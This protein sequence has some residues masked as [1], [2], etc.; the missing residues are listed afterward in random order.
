V[1]IPPEM[2][3]R[4]GDGRGEGRSGSGSGDV[5]GGMCIPPEMVRRSGDGAGE[6][7]RGNG[8]GNVGGG[9]GEGVCR[10]VRRWQRRQRR[11]W[12]R[13]RRRRGQNLATGGAVPAGSAML[14][15]FAFRL[16][17]LSFLS[18]PR[19]LPIFSDRGVAIMLDT[20]YRLSK[21]ALAGGARGI[22]AS[23]WVSWPLAAA[24]H[25]VH[26]SRPS[27][28]QRPSVPRLAHGAWIH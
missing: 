4:G 16:A 22:I 24:R 8:S 12:W 13:R 18:R 23:S 15:R 1:W 26:A 19:P 28:L 21:H 11:G 2:V 5:G 9:G 25:P 17:A 14:S 3:R 10:R 27:I 7:S 6:G 20:P